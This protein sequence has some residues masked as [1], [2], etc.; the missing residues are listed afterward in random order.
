MFSPRARNRLP[1]PS[2]FAFGHSRP[3]WLGSPQ[4]QQSLEPIR[5]IERP[6]DCPDEGLLADLLWAD[7]DMW[8]KGFG[9]SDR[10]ISYMFGADAVEVCCMN[11][12]QRWSL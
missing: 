9:P 11:N 5:R 7:P 10:G 12:T 1:L 6:Q 4:I 2:F 3:Q 8:T